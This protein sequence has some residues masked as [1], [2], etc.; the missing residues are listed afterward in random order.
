MYENIFELS[1]GNIFLWLAFFVLAIV[2]ICRVFW[3]ESSFRTW[4]WELRCDNKK[5]RRFCQILL[6]GALC[7]LM[8]FASLDDMYSANLILILA[9]TVVTAIIAVVWVY[10]FQAVSIA[11]ASFF[12]LFYMIGCY[13]FKK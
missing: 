5:M 1:L 4:P 7:L 6:F 10:L 3:C 11:V 8:L 13:F 2:A 12:Y 9:G